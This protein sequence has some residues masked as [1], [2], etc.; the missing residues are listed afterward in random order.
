L[1]VGGGLSGS[2]DPDHANN[3]AVATVDVTRLTTPTPQRRVS[4]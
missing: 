4:W 2:P 3:V 1:V